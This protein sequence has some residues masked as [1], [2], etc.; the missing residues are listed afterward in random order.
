[1]VNKD[2]KFDEDL[3]YSSEIEWIEEIVVP[4][5]DLEVK[6]KSD[7]KVDE[8]SLGVDMPSPSTPTCKRPRWLNQTL[9]EAQGHVPTSRSLV[10]ES[11]PPRRYAKHI[12]LVSSICGPSSCLE[13]E[14]CHT[15]MEDDVCVDFKTTA[16]IDLQMTGLVELQRELK[17]VGENTFLLKR[18]C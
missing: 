18:E 8:V 16:G 12:A 2:V 6:A 7:S 14:R 4:K 10:R 5:D 11:I 13:E 3:R 9:Q 1:V 15:L 17:G